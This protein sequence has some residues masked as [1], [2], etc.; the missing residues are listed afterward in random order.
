MN[1]GFGSLS[2]KLS[3][4]IFYCLATTPSS[5]RFLPQIAAAASACGHR[6]RDAGCH[7]PAHWLRR[8]RSVVDACGLCEADRRG[9]AILDRRQAARARRER[10]ERVRSSRSTAFRKPSRSSPSP[11]GDEPRQCRRRRRSRRGS[12]HPKLCALDVRA[13]PWQH[14]SDHGGRG[15]VMRCWSAFPSW[16]GRAPLC[17]AGSAARSS[18]RIPCS[19][20]FRSG[21]GA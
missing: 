14:S 2:C 8:R 19:R 16:F 11:S 7:H 13:R 12:K 5:S 18:P 21:D 9:A 1:P 15:L 6:A 3:G 10:Q 4:L 20:Q 17:S